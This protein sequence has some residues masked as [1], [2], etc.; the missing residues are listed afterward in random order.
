MDTWRESFALQQAVQQVSEKLRPMTLLI[1]R[2]EDQEEVVRFHEE[3]PET[4]LQTTLIEYLQ[5]MPNM[6][7]AAIRSEQRYGVELSMN[8]HTLEVPELFGQYFSRYCEGRRSMEDI[9]GM[10]REEDYDDTEYRKAI[11]MH[12]TKESALKRHPLSSEEFRSIVMGQAAEL[13]LQMYLRHFLHYANQAD[14]GKELMLLTEQPGSKIAVNTDY[15]LHFS[16]PHNCEL[17]DRNTESRRSNKREF[18]AVMV[19]GAAGEQFYFFDACTSVDMLKKKLRLEE[20]KVRKLQEMLQHDNSRILSH[21][22]HVLYRDFDTVYPE[23][24]PAH[25]SVLSLPHLHQVGSIAD[26]TIKWLDGRS[27]GKRLIDALEEP[28]PA[29]VH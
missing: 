16:S 18:D 6:H 8:P 9:T 12:V 10:L 22:F 24:T 26:K 21:I 15:G 7:V 3:H 5:Q 19:A 28:R 23:E 2:E 25:C 13:L 17:Y 14:Q 11:R 1:G 29:D 27:S 4:N 20:S